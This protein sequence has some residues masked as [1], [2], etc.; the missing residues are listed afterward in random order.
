MCNWRVISSFATN[1]FCKWGHYGSW[2]WCHAVREPPD[3]QCGKL[4]GEFGHLKMNLTW[5]LGLIA[6]S[7]GSRISGKFQDDQSWLLGDQKASCDKGLRTTVL[8]KQ[9]GL[10]IAFGS[11]APQQK[12]CGL[13]VNT[14]AE[15]SVEHSNHQLFHCV[16]HPSCKW[17]HDS[18]LSLSEDLHMY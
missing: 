12:G 15:T 10:L 11:L 2:E 16:I 18:Y 14:M 1:L 7:E 3:T 6:A 13:W 4:Q 5:G 17:C 8:L 9:S